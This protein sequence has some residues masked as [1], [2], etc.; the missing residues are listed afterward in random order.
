VILAEAAIHELVAN[1]HDQVRI[2]RRLLDLSQAQ[3]GALQ[4]HDVHAVQAVLQEIELAMLERSKVD[5]RREHAIAA[6]ASRLGIA[7]EEVTAARLQHAAPGALGATIADASAELKDLIAQLD[8]VV[9]RSNALL[10]HELQLIEFMMD[11]L[12]TVRETPTYQRAGTQGD[13]VRRSI[14]DTAV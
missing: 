1:L 7:V 4:R 13:G 6:V 8:T 2:Y 12:T 5:Q 10:Q 9:A 14:L 3:V 11:G